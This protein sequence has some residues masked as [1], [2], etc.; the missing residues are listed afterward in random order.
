[1]QSIAVV[2]Q[3]GGV[4]KTTATVNLGHALA[5]VGKRVLI[6][7]LDPQGH[8]GSCLGLFRLS[9]HGIDEVL[10]DGEDLMS[11]ALSVRDGLWLMPPGNRLVEV[12]KLAG[13]TERASLLANALDDIED[14][15]DVVL[16]DCPPSAGLLIVNAVVAADD[17]AIPVAGDYLSLTG[18]ARFMQTIQRLQPLR[19]TPL[20]QWVFMSRFVA[21]RRLAREVFDKVMEHFSPYLLATSISEAAALAECAGAGQ[22]IFEYREKCRSAAEFTELATDVLEGRIFTNEQKE[23]SHVA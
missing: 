20:R 22:T 5:R 8:V 1:M 7:D 13:G 11:R 21:R 2:N 17:V 19:R 12:E 18:L 16:F 3:K 9:G 6:I 15:I 4:G 14:D 23:T 10:L